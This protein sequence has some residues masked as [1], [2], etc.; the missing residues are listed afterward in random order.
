M[1]RI[2]WAEFSILYFLVLV[3]ILISKPVQ[4][5][6]IPGKIW[7]DTDNKP[8]EAHGGGILKVGEIYYWYGENHALGIGNKTGISCFSSH[9]L[10]NWKNEGVVFP[11][12]ELPLMFQ[13]SGVCE[14][15][16][17]LYN[18][19]THKYVMWMHLDA[20]Q[21]TV[22]TAG[23]AV[24]DS[25]S[26]KFKFLGSQRPINYDY[27]YKKEQ[28]VPGFDSREKELGNTFRDM[29]LFQDDDGKA[30]LIYSSEEL[31]TL[32]CV[33]LNESYTDIERPLAKGKTWERIF[34][35]QTREAPAPFKF[36]GKY[37]LFTSGTSGW[38]PN[39]AQLA[40]ADHLFGPWKT[41]GNPCIG[42]ESLTTFGSQSTY[43]LPAPGKPSG[44]F[45]YMGDRWNGLNLEKSTYV[46][47]PFKMN[48][49][50]GFKLVFFDQWDMSIFDQTGE[51]LKSPMIKETSTNVL[52]WIPVADADGYK[53][54]KNGYFVSFTRETQFRIQEEFAGQVFNYSV[55]AWKVNGQLSKP[56]NLL[57]KNWTLAKEL[58]LS[59]MDA[60]S[61]KQGWGVLQ[62]DKSIQ[63]P[64][65][66]IAGIEFQKGLGTHAPAETVYRI[67][68][69]YSIFSA[70]IGVDDYTR[71]Y[72]LASVQFEVWG[73]G[74]MLYQ[75]KIMKAEDPAV[76]VNVDITGINEL[77][78][79]VNDGG[80]G[81]DW[82][83]ADW[84]EAKINT[85]K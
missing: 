3:F 19:K 58:Y 25:P 60:E 62:K 63:L 51:P 85:K 54:F 70:R 84:A 48:E 43:V 22:A 32:Y 81:Q 55:Q 30:Y 52:T 46:W 67:C 42:A 9:D 75:S 35:N 13:D 1:K 38:D 71:T 72:H 73:D 17:V 27:G 53:V 28:R 56:S 68:G 14:R 5:Q 83:H 6:F 47:L 61:S 10:Q 21:Y 82:D 59:D 37:Y 69:N 15:P 41:I 16:K 29:A 77:K 65:I 8:I 24:S 12:E 64:K 76:E 49:Y 45:I 11:K 18:A 7:L 26:G 23:V 50:G 33:Q 57:T 36:N 44:S 78:L 31:V 20:N 4:S 80:D 39:P 66:K 79:I 74:M 34:V 40:V 2:F